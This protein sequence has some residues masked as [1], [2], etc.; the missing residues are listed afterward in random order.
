M[1]VG[2]LVSAVLSRWLRI[3]LVTVLL[4]V[5][6]ASILMFVPKVYE[7]SASIL[8]EP[9]ENVY[10][11]A[12]GETSSGG[13]SAG[14]E[15]ALMSSQIELIK[16]RDLLLEVIGSEGLRSVPEFAK[17]AFSPVG[18]VMKL[19]GRGG[20][21]ADSLDETVL[22]NLSESMT[23]IRERDSAVIS[24]YVRSKDPALAARLANAIAAAHVKRRAQQS[25]TD[26][27]DATVWLEQ[28]IG[29]LRGKVSEA[30]TAVANYKIDND[31][32]VGTNATPVTDQQLSAVAQQIADAQQR[33]NA[34]T[35]RAQVIRGLI[36]S[37]QSLEG[38]ADVRNSVVVQS[39]LQT[40][41]ALQGDLAQRS[42]TLLANHPTIKALKAQIRE[43][44]QQVALEADKVADSLEAEAEVES[45]LELRLR[46]D[47]TRAKITA[48]DATKGGVTLDSL[49]REAKAQ[50]DLL[51]NYLAKYSDAVSRTAS[52]ATLPDVRVISEAAPSTTPSSPKTALILGAVG[53][54]ALALQVGAALFGELM[55]GRALVERGPRTGRAAATPEPVLAAEAL[56]E[57]EAD[58]DEAL[59]HAVAEAV[60]RPMRYVPAPHDE[61]SAFS[62]DIHD[63]PP[64][65][66]LLASV[67]AAH[68]S[69]QVIERLL[70][71]AIM[72]RQTAVVVDAGSGEMSEALGLTDLAAD[73]AEY[74]DVIQLAGENLAEVRWGRQPELDRNSTRPLILVQALAD[75][76]QLVIVDTGRAGMGSSLP[77]FAGVADHARLVLVASETAN[78][79]AV[80]AARHDIAMLGFD[81][82]RVVHLSAA[83]ADVA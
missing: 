48:S 61:L 77:L 17:P 31:L 22:A 82:D 25:L 69:L 78:P 23:V 42:T 72:E 44:E 71:D 36:G 55:S 75:L 50:R 52:S 18:A 80:A 19:L 67:G 8:V 13:G 62:A 81:A 57:P 46:E 2:A 45:G 7:S 76:Y 41:A 5:A 83:Q 63:G 6:T 28:E 30:E 4:L 66:I 68:E 32:F 64:G 34:A 16:S 24:I 1:D 73:G 11:R 35:S 59:E 74:A 47:L 56:P 38:V 14:N 29:K 26:T 51:E 60:A 39:L 43:I 10:T 49:E 58:S 21:E 3:V 33:K 15:A 79:V 9:R 12:P 27:A 53:F 54:V 37:G 65:V 70:E 40:K 20:N